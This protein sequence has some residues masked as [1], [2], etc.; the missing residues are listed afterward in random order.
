M[1]WHQVGVKVYG[2]DDA[3]EFP[4]ALPFWAYVLCAY[5]QPRLARL[6]STL[7][8][9][10]INTATCERLFS[11]FALI[12]TAKRN[13]LSPGKVKKISVV[14]Q[15]VRNLNANQ[16]TTSIRSASSGRIVDAKERQ[17]FVQ[18]E[19]E[20]PDVDEY[21]PIADDDT[22]DERAEDD[23]EPAQPSS[24]GAA[25]WAWAPTSCL[26]TRTVWLKFSKKAKLA[27]S[28]PAR[29]FLTGRRRPSR[30]R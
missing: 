16:G 24:S 8:S 26:T 11:E 19:E 1:Q 13:R 3:A 22:D 18:V 6:A 21:E 15:S 28:G 5:K 30:L 23:V 29:T 20:E 10:V 2:V 9:V 25:Y 7:L 17:L 12:H 4:S 27:K 14:R